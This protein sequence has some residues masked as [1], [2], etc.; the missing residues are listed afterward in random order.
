EPTTNVG[1]PIGMISER[2]RSPHDEVTAVHA[3]PPEEPRGRI[4][5][6]RP[7]EI[8]DA[9]PPSSED[10]QPVALPV[11]RPKDVE[12]RPISLTPEKTARRENGAHRAGDDLDA[13]AAEWG[14]SEDRLSRVLRRRRPRMVEATAELERLLRKPPRPPAPSKAEARS[15]LHDLLERK[16]HSE[17][18][19]A[20][21]D[22]APPSGKRKR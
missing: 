7:I 9:P 17:A 6:T 1:P 2:P 5:A 18:Q 10:S 22:E 4:E 19:A 3:L 12:T 13:L 15:L 20:G 16:P 11:G 21:G 14:L 8:P